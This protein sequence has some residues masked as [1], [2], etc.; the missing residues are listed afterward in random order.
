MRQDE[1]GLGQAGAEVVWKA[2]EGSAEDKRGKA[3][4]YF[5]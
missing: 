5:L 3:H 4:G 1:R 2:E